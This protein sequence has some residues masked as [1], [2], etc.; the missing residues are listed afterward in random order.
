MANRVLLIETQLLTEAATAAGPECLEQQRLRGCKAAC[1]SCM[2]QVGAARQLCFAEPVT[3][4]CAVCRQ[5]L[6]SSK[7]TTED[8]ASLR[9]VCCAHSP[10]RAALVTLKA[11]L[12][13]GRHAAQPSPAQAPGCLGLQGV[14]CFELQ[15]V[16]QTG[17]HSAMATSGCQGA[18]SQ[19][20]AISRSSCTAAWSYGAAEQDH[21]EQ[22]ERPYA[23]V[24]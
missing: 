10:L 11:R 22:R 23:A 8:A 9:P 5:S 12:S 14:E 19:V 13:L 15:L 6:L 21:T 4:V 7:R 1:E 24:A 3:D 18:R 17:C 2:Q 20:V 16:Q